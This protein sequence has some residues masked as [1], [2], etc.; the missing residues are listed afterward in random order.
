MLYRQIKTVLKIPKHTVYSLVIYSI[1]LGFLSL[2]IPV[3]VQTLVNLVGVSLSIRPVISLIIL[4]IFL[5]AAFF[6]RIFQLKLVEDI[7]RKV[8]VETVLRIISAI[9]KVDFNNLIRVN[10][11]EKIN[12]AFDKVFTKICFCDIYNST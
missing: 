7:Q 3:S 5:T 2:T 8:F 1:L 9:Y 4:F 11:R 6:V 12:R 10:V